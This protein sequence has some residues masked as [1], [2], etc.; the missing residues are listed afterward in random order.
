[1]TTTI[2]PTTTIVPLPTIGYLAVHDDMHSAALRPPAMTFLTA[3]LNT[4]TQGLLDYGLQGG[5]NVNIDAQYG[6]WSESQLE[7]KAETFM[8]SSYLC[9]V[10]AD[11]LAAMALLK[12]RAGHPKHPPIIMALCGHPEKFVARRMRPGGRFTGLTNDVAN[13]AGTR[14]AL[15]LRLLQLNG[16]TRATGKVL[17]YG[18]Y[19][20]SSVEKEELTSGG[21]D[22]PPDVT[23][24]SDIGWALG[25]IDD[26]LRHVPI[27]NALSAIGSPDW[28]YVASD[29]ALNSRKKIIAD[30]LI[31]TDP[32]SATRRIPAVY[33]HKDFVEAGGLMSYGPDRFN[34]LMRRVGAFVKRVF[35]GATDNNLAAV[36]FQSPVAHELWINKATATTLGL[37]ALE[38]PTNVGK[39]LG[40]PVNLYTPP[41]TPP[42]VTTTSPPATTPP[43][44]TTTSLPVTTMAPSTTASAGSSI[45]QQ[46][47]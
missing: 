24:I 44:A 29:P 30:Y 31:G 23:G 34:D 43:P 27:I 35:D 45:G 19:G 11:S 8:A 4:F 42:P 10:A 14:I 39:L 6:N 46:R 1:M 5:I 20:M 36:P 15:L 26:D 3:T 12:K 41:T 7:S 17:W 9:I 33:G 16:K 47:R 28:V 32:P 18:R 21:P 38:D 40:I 13:Q 25:D 22:W 2:M 37:T